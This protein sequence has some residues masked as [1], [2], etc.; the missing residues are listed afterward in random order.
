M[1][2]TAAHLVAEKRGTAVNVIL[3]YRRGSVIVVMPKIK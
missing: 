3:Q 1:A 2:E